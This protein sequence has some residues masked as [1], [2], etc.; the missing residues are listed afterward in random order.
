MPYTTAPVGKGQFVNVDNSGLVVSGRHTLTKAK[1]RKQLVAIYLSKKAK[2][3][4][5]N[6]VFKSK[7]KKNLL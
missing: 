3:Q 7:N 2:G 4:S 6:D 1:A 5:G